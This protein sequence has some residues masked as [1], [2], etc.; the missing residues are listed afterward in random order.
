MS[1][2]DEIENIISNICTNK[3]C[4]PNSIPIRILKMCKN[5]LA[6]PPSDVFNIS[7]A[8]GKFPNSM[9]NLNTSIKKR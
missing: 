9:K 1:C 7:F 5:E 6:K 8:V 4:D 2:K 3:T